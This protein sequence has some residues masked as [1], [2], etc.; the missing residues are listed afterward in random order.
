M[1]PT[2]AL[3]SD[4]LELRRLDDRDAEFVEALY[5]DARVTRA[6]LQIQQPISRAQ[7]LEFCRARPNDDRFGAVLVTSRQLVG[8]GTV[9]R[10]PELPDVA[11]IGYSVLP[12][13]WNQGLGTELAG[14]LVEFASGGPGLR[15]VRATTLK[16]HRASARILQKLGFVIRQAGDSELD[17]RGSP[18][19][20]TRWVLHTQQR[21]GGR[22]ARTD[23]PAAAAAML[24]RRPVAEV[25]QAFVDPAITSRFWFSRGSGRLEVG[26]Q[27]TWEWEPYRASAQVLVK[28]IEPNA[29]IVVEWSAYGTPTTVEWVF[30]PRPDHTTFVSI[31]NTGF[32]GDD[33]EIARQAVSSTEGFTLVLAGLKAWLE[34]RIALNL[35]W[36]R[37][38]D[39]V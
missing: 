34:H 27:V 11:T 38:P 23:A 12:A 22:M 1:C 19:R 8:L 21:D 10:S 26:K 20:V 32:R 9:R 17:S 36:D 3:R 31:T 13:F 6:L 33:A 30:A 16:D 4:R 39:G 25:F 14:L 18:R 2:V 29:R 37:F 15:E 28:A 5:A 24:I 35:V 7:A